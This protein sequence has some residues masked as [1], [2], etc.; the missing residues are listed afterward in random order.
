MTIKKPK[1][2]FALLQYSGMDTRLLGIK[3][4]H[5]VPME[6][7]STHCNTGQKP[8]TN[9]R[10]THRAAGP[11]PRTL[12]VLRQLARAYMPVPAM[13]GVVLN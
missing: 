13:P 3:H 1:K 4:L 6:M 7:T 2:T 11:S 12:A 9:S 5:Y 10:P 8:N